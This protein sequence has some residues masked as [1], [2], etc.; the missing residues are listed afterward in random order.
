MATANEGNAK[1]GRS[2]FRYSENGEL[3]SR[4]EIEPQSIHDSSFQ[5]LGKVK[6]A[7]MCTQNEIDAVAAAMKNKTTL[8]A[9]SAAKMRAGKGKRHWSDGNMGN[10]LAQRARPSHGITVLPKSRPTKKFCDKSK[11]KRYYY[12]QLDP[13]VGVPGPAEITAD[14]AV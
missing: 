1:T 7:L 5:G 4:K 13:M 8:E 11:E 10:I 6:P 2:K 3:F 12:A 14:S 9:E